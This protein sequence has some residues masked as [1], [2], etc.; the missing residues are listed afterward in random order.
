MTEWDIGLI[1]EAKLSNDFEY[2]H[3]FNLI[4][5]ADSEEARYILNGI[6]ERL[7][8]RYTRQNG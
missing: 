3:V 8:K 4:E 1:R 2:M 7:H 5:M 6:A